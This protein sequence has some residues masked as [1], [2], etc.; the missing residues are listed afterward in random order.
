MANF[1]EILTSVHARNGGAPRS[2][3]PDE[4]QSH[5]R[6]RCRL[7]R[8]GVMEYAAELALKNRALHEFWTGHGLDV[9]CRPLIP[10]PRG[11][12]YRAVTKRK[13]FHARDGVHLGLIDPAADGNDKA[14]EVV[15]CAIEPPLHAVVFDHVRKSITKPFAA[16]LASALRYVVIR[17]TESDL[18]VIFTVGAIE[19]PILKSANALSKS[20][21]RACDA[22]AGV[23][24]FEDHGRGTH[25]LGTP[26]PSAMPRTRTIF[27]STDMRTTVCGRSFIHSPFSFSQ[28]NPSVLDV[29]VTTAGSLLALSADVRLFD[30]YCGYGLFALCLSPLVHDVRGIDASREGIRSAVANAH[31]QRQGN[32]WFSAGD[33]TPT[34]VARLLRDARP[35]D[36]VL[37]DPPRN[38]PAEGVLDAIASRRPGR[39]VHVFCA[40]D[41]LPA[42]VRRWAANGYRAVE[43][44]PLDMFPGTDAVEM[45]VVL[46]RG[47]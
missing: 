43:A 4:C 47:S 6:Q 17:G 28:V 30:L 38:G 27:G 14:F 25:Y 19:P 32:A 29:F 37:L 23:F 3:R 7:C 15:S 22:I 44:V 45:M 35:E 10:S 1:S 34:S 46:E 20:L 18:R 24:I 42:D 8:A 41:R 39:V 40:I 13:A 33:I 5:N 2:L 26:G 12:G 9:P 36:R 11:R 16:P 31:R 21:S